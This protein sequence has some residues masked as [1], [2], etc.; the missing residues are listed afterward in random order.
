MNATSKRYFEMAYEYQIAALTLYTQIPS[1]SYIY[2]P[3][4][5][6]FRHAI[7]LILKGLIIAEEKKSRRVRVDEIMVGN[8]KLDEIHSLYELWYKYTSLNKQ[9]DLSSK[10]F[11]DKTIGKFNNRDPFSER[12]RYPRSKK[13]KKKNSR[14]YPLEPV[15]ISYADKSPDLEDGIPFLIETNNSAAVVERGAYLLQEINDIVLTTELL[16]DLSEK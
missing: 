12:F 9:I 4:A 13:T 5:Y 16:F 6:L 1:A 8:K 7:E 10:I 14:N 11:I 2:N 3:T 15:L